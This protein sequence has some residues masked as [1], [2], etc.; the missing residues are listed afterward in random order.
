MSILLAALL[1]LIQGLAEFLP[2][3]SSGHL[4]LLQALFGVQMEHQLLFNILLHVGTL[5]AVAIVFW[6]DWVQMIAH[7]I[8][9]KTLLLLFIASLP[10]LVA[11]LL[12]GDQLDYLETHNILLGACFLLTGLLLVLAQWLSKRNAQKHVEKTQVGVGEA[13]AMGCMQAVG[14]LPGVSRS[15]ST[16]FG[17]VAV[18]LN[19]ETAAKFSFMMS[20]PAIVA[21]MLSEGYA[22]MKE[23]IH[24]GGDLPAILVGMLVAG[25]SGYFAIRFFLKLL[26][27][28]SL[29]W[30]ALYVAIIGILVIVLQMT[31]VMKDAPVEA[32]TTG[33]NSLASF[34]G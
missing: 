10:A 23:G 5:G 25:V 19:R 2:V 22:V 1:G 26:T 20:A 31:G 21:G 28:V 13:I 32:V 9:N 17:G 30:F 27:K 7:P 8:Q 18:R 15:G 4:N 29:N 34:I 12:F 16:L 11:K 33:L 24:I 6:K 14:M 3:S